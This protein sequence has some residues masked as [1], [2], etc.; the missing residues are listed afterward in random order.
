MSTSTPDLLWRGQRLIV[1]V[2]GWAFHR[3][4]AKFEADRRRDATPIAAGWLALRFTAR[5]IRD[6]LYAV[7]ARI[8]QTLWWRSAALE[9]VS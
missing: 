2:D 5:Q 6:Q 3:G 8:A 4:R 1:E 9:R 7:S